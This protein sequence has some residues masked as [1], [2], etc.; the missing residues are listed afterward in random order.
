M[1]RIKIG[2]LPSQRK[3]PKVVEA[4]PV[5]PKTVHK[6]VDADL[7]GSYKDKENRSYIVRIEKYKG[8]EW[9]EW[10]PDLGSFKAKQFMPL[11]ESILRKRIA[12]GELTKAA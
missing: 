6:Q 8:D 9:F 7:I 11:D 12:D 2:N 3:K 10:A 1:A 5:Q 4:Q